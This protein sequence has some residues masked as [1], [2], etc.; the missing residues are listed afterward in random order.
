MG[1][2]NN[3]FLTSHGSTMWTPF[4]K[5][6]NEHDRELTKQ[7]EIIELLD[8]YL[9]KDCISIIVLYTQPETPFDTFHSSQ[10]DIIKGDLDD[11]CHGRDE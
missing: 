9:D 6:L 4:E 2:S 3:K 8:A 10:S 11:K 5:Q 1:N 7:K